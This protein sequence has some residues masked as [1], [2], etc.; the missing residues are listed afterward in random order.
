MWGKKLGFRAYIANT[1]KF[2]EWIS[3]DFLVHGARNIHSTYRSLVKPK[4]G[5]RNESFAEAIV[6]LGLSEHEISKQKRYYLM[7]SSLY[8]V[9]LLLGCGYA[10]WLLWVVQNVSAA[11]MAALY[12]FL[13]FAFF[14]RESFWYM[15]ISTRR[16]GQNM[17]DWTAFMLHNLKLRRR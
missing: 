2:S 16:L 1:F 6:R 8:G 13:M 10:A 15:Q 11:L 7:T 12:C 17:Q 3:K 5:V 4:Q 9:C 14:F